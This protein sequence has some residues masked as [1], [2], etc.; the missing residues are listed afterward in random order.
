M[1]KTAN[2]INE[3]EYIKEMLPVL[4]ETALREL[5]TFT[6]YLADRERRRKALVE[7]VLKAEKE[8]PIRFKAVKDAM[9]AIRDEAGI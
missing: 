1:P 2:T 5:R 3:A 9:K 8:K 7:R 4:S 6:D